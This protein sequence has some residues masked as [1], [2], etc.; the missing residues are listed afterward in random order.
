MRIKRE[1]S[2]EGHR[3]DADIHMVLIM[4]I[5]TRDPA[6]A[7]QDCSGP[8][9]FPSSLSPTLSVLARH[10]GG[11]LA[12]WLMGYCLRSAGTRGAQLALVTGQLFQ[13]N[14]RG[15]SDALTRRGAPGAGGCRAGCQPSRVGAVLLTELL[16]TEELPLS[17]EQVSP[18]SRAAVPHPLGTCSGLR[19]RRGR[20]LV[21]LGVQHPPWLPATH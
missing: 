15:L 8:A 6:P 19:L 18:R 14:P 20:C 4:L 12:S 10:W 3:G 17:G 13:T 16:D 1:S 21:H 5:S 11:G 9:P 2:H 7:P